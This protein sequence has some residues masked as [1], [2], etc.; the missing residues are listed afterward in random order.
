[1]N[2]VAIKKRGRE[3]VK[4]CGFRPAP[5]FIICNEIVFKEPEHQARVSYWF[6]Y[7]RNCSVS[8]VTNS[9]SFCE[10]SHLF[11]V[12]GLLIIEHA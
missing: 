12:G 8:I 2:S 4:A 11:I 7:D 3:E 9:S 6:Q 10:E 5:I 1:M